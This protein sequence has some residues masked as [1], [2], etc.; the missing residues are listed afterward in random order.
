MEEYS[1]Y[2]EK[3]NGLISKWGKSQTLA[4]LLSS[5]DSDQERLQQAIQDC[6]VLRYQ[7]NEL[8]RAREEAW[9]AKS[10]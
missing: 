9:K 10:L 8:V 3:L 7:I 4:D 2:Q 1:D 5:F 6:K